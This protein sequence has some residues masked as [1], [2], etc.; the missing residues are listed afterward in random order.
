MQSIGVCRKAA[1]IL[2]LGVWYKNIRYNIP[3]ITLVRVWPD[4]LSPRENLSHPR[5]CSG[6]TLLFSGRQTV[7]SHS[8][9]GDNCT[10]SRLH[11][12]SMFSVWYIIDIGARAIWYC[13]Y[14]FM[15]IVLVLLCSFVFCFFFFFTVFYTKDDFFGKC[16]ET[17]LQFEL[18][19]VGTKPGSLTSGAYFNPNDRVFCM[20]FVITCIPHLIFMYKFW[21]VL[22][23][24]SIITE[25][26]FCQLAQ[27]VSDLIVIT[28]SNKIKLI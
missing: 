5:A 4:G 17:H 2:L 20:F 21:L 12:R 15:Q 22:L 14:K 18:E 24:L 10:R 27:H 7:G 9:K 3:I 25:K 8:N 13:V 6:V 11:I 19:G 16:T 23:S 1:C 28:C 26:T